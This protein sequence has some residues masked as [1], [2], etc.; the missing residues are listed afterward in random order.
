MTDKCRLASIVC[1]A[2]EQ[3]PLTLAGAAHQKACQTMVMFRKHI[4]RFHHHYLK[5]SLIIDQMLPS[6]VLVPR[7]QAYD[8][9]SAYPGSLCSTALSVSQL[10]FEYIGHTVG[11]AD[12]QNQQQSQA[13]CFEKKLTRS[14]KVSVI[15]SKSHRTA[16]SKS[17]TAA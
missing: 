14:S 13:S 5:A 12:K 17:H 10:P 11:P 16:V 9:C 1:M 8:I 6:N 3:L 7:H 2:R 15:T 4:Q